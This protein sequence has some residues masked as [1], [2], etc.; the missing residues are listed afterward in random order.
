MH[1]R[2]SIGEDPGSVK[3]V[4]FAGRGRL[5]SEFLQGFVIFMSIHTSFATP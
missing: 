2:F 5:L 4:N 1:F 3:N